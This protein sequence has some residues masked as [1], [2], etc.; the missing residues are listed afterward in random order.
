MWRRGF[1]ASAGGA[2]AGDVE[3]LEL[4]AELSGL[5][6]QK[7]LCLDSDVTV[8]NAC[9]QRWHLICDLRIKKYKIYDQ[10]IL[11]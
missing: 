4:E 11:I 9:P 7:R 5:E 3:Q 8:L 6:S 10:V 1:D 2:A